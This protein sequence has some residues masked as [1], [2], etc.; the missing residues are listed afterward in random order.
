MSDHART[1]YFRWLRFLLIPAVMAAVFMLLPGAELHASP[2]D[3]SASSAAQI[4][5][6]DVKK[7]QVVAQ[8]AVTEEIRQELRKLAQS[9]SGSAGTFRI[10]PGDGTVLHFPLQPALEIR[11]PGFFA[12]AAEAYLF[13]PAG[14]EPYM[15]F[16]SEENEP[17]L[18]GVKHPVKPLLS[19]CGWEDAYAPS[20]Q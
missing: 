15:L 7:G 13:L 11:Q 14:R 1:G 18:F 6:F 12:L 5:R 9:A 16:F 2:A 4:E 3:E 8:L 17:R 19:L 20:G 10:D